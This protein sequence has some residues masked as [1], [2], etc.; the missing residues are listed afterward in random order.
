M[1]IASRRFE[2]RAP[3]ERHLSA[4]NHIGYDKIDARTHCTP[5]E[6]ATHCCSWL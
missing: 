3:E 1:F 2:C 4:N 5:P 6:R